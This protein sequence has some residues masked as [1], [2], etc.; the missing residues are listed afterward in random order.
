MHLADF[1]HLLR[2]NDWANQAMLAA[3]A[4]LADEGLDRPFEMGMGTL[5]RTIIHI[6]NGEWVWMNRWQGN[7]ET[8]W[9]DESER[10]SVAALRDR[11]ERAAAARDAYLRGLGDSALGETVVYRDSK[12]GRFQATRGDM[13]FQMFVHSTHHRAQAANMIR[14][15]DAGLLELDYMMSLRKLA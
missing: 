13:F 4:P 10:V 7:A 8:P 12:G 5:R 3:A 6:Y 2:Y 11:F 9:P 1:Q 14:Q 15:L